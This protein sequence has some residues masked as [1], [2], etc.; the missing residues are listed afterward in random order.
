MSGG[1]F[2]YAYERPA[3]FAN[4][5]RNKLREQG[6]DPRSEGWPAPVW[7]T[8]VA[9]ALSK[10]AAFAD[11]VSA[12]MKEAEWLYSGDTSEDTFAERLRQIEATRGVMSIE[13]K[14]L[15]AR[16]NRIAPEEN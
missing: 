1:S 5:L 12:L 14:P 6:K 16:G 7:N 8:D 13:R 9:C 11:Y 10:I 2:D 15:N 4:E 3:R